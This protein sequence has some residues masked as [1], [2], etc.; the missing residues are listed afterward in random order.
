M[1]PTRVS[2]DSNIESVIDSVDD[3]KDDIPKQLQKRLD[4]AMRVLWADVKQYILDDPNASGR[5]FNEL[6]RDQEIGDEMLR[7]TVYTDPV[8]TKYAAI[9][10]FGSGQPKSGMPWPGGNPA[11]GPPDKYPPK[12]PFDSPSVDYPDSN[13]EIIRAWNRNSG[14]YDTF[15]AL[16]R[17]IESWMRWKGIVSHIGDRSIS[18]MFITREIIQNGTYAHP[19]MRPAWF[20]NELNIKKAVINGVKAAA[21]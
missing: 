13:G 21:R 11:R 17:I 2:I 3:V 8:T 20:D 9:T 18:A 12:Y 1:T 10:E 16:S 14:R 4:R 15:F 19:Y 7:F 5:L 6:D